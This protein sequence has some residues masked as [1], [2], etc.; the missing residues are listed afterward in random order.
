MILHEF[1]PVHKRAYQ[2][3]IARMGRGVLPPNPI[4]MA[5]IEIACAA[6][7]ACL[8]AA[9]GVVFVRWWLYP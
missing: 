6:V 3:E 5:L 4:H 9:F 2:R 1:V 7:C 8:I